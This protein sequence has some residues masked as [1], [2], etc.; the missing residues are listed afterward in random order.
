MAHLDSPEL[1]SL[2]CQVA[3]SIA[4]KGSIRRLLGGSVSWG[5]RL[6][7]LPRLLF[8]FCV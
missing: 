7:L 3:A 5:L 8:H 2:R 6:R 1:A 4:G